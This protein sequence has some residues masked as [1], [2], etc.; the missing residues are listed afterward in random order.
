MTVF[1]EL[2]DEVYENLL[3]YTRSQEQTT[4]SLQPINETDL[5]FTVADASQI[6]RGVIE[7]GDEMI[8]V[9]RKDSV[10]NTVT[11]PPYGRGYLATAAAVHNIGDRIIN[12]PRTPRH[13][14]GQAINQTI[15]SVYPDLYAVKT[16]LFPYVAARLHYVL[17]SDADTLLSAEW[18]PP[19]PSLVWMPLRFWRQSTTAKSVDVEIGDS[20]MPGRPVRLTYGARP[21]ELDDIS[22]DFCDT[23]LDDNC[24]DVVVYGACSRLIG[25][26][27]SSRLQ[28][29]SIESQTQAQLIPPGSTL[30]AG[31]YF[32]QLFKQRLAEEQRR[33]QLRHRVAVHRVQ[34]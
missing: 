32:F 6:S 9:E 22:V 17:P 16:T 1:A 29:E 5:T 15:R 14:I 10:Q 11:V 24:R 26:A 20:I 21:C 4:H 8:Y 19:G 33:L 25:F 18:Q 12:N 28:S 7:I 2:K 3:G 27:E 34:F 13:I 30:N 23:G 31:R